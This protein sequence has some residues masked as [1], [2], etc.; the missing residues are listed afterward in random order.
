MDLGPPVVGHTSVVF[1]GLVHAGAGRNPQ[2][3]DLLA[4]VQRGVHIHHRAV[5]GGDG[6]A[7]SPGDAGG[8]EQGV[9]HQRGR[10]RVGPLDV[11]VGEV[12]EF[13]GAWQCGVHRQPPCRQAVLP[14]TTHGT[15]VTRAE[16]GHH[17]VLGGGVVVDPKARKPE[18]GGQGTG[19]Q[20]TLAKIEHGGV[21]G[22]LLRLPVTDLE[23][24]HRAFEE[25][26]EVEKLHLEAQAFV[27]PQ[28]MVRP[29]LDALEL[30]VVHRSHCGWQGACVGLV[31]RCGQ[32][33]GAALE[34]CIVKRLGAAGGLHTCGLGGGRQGQLC[35]D[36]AC[37][38]S[39]EKFS[40]LHAHVLQIRGLTAG[41]CQK[42]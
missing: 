4:R 37:T 25:H 34:L 17:I 13:F 27:R 12:R 14:R 24:P 9:H 20:A 36:Q 11:E 5:A 2:S 39:A 18:V 19:G 26:A 29:E 7:V 28:C 32:H 10:G 31:G 23:H 38:C 35:S 42:C 15:E 16:E 22:Q 33:P 40:S 3:L 1:S 21:V 41:C 30:V 6:K 8:V